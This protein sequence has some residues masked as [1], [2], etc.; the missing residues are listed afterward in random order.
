[1]ISCGMRAPAQELF[2]KDLTSNGVQHD[3]AAYHDLSGGAICMS[4]D[5]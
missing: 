3:E 1:M 5:G 2:S 4:G